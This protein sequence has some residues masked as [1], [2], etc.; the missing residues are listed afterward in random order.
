MLSVR[1]PR[2]HLSSTLIY[3]ISTWVL[4]LDIIL[5]LYSFYNKN[6]A[7]LSVSN[8]VLLNVFIIVVVLVASE[9]HTNYPISVYILFFIKILLFLSVLSRFHDT[10]KFDI[11]TM[12]F[13]IVVIAIYYSLVSG[14]SLAPHTAC[15]PALGIYLRMRSCVRWFKV[16]AVLSSPAKR[17]GGLRGEVSWPGGRRRSSPRIFG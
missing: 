8:I 4:L 1:E 16:C 11:Y 13:S 17:R 3:Q 15:E 7:S 5:L 6:L 14:R 2:I 10:L 12:T 9:C